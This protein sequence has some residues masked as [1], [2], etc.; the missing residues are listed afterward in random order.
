[1]LIESLVEQLMSFDEIIFDLDNTIYPQQ[2][3]DRGAFE[4]ITKVLRT[5]C[6]LPLPDF[7]EDLL[8]FK[9]IK[10]NKYNRLFNDVLSKY[11]LPETLLPIMLAHY[12][13]H[14]G[15]YINQA[16]SLV[17]IIKSQL[18]HKKIFIVTNGLVQVQT[19]KVNRLGLNQWLT[20]VICSATKP[21]QLKPSRYAFDEITKQH[22]CSN[23][24]MVGDDLSTDGLFAQAVNIPFL[25]F[26]IRQT[27]EYK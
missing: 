16:H 27:N 22:A 13:N 15:R 1:M 23:P 21:E 3:Y 12:A 24:V 17:P 6:V 19:T 10:G 5:E 9:E 18:S 20:V 14:D 7:A 11:Q 2:D 26:D 8:A 4:D 25:H